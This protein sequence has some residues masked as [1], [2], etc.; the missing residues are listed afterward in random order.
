M[1]ATV[2]N[3]GRFATCAWDGSIIIY[4]NKTRKPDLVIQEHNI[5]VNYILQLS[6]GMLVSCSWDKSIKIFNIKHNNYQ[7]LQTLNYH[8]NFVYKVIELNN[9]NLISCS[10]DSSVIIYSKDNNNKYTKDYKITTNS[11]CFCVIQTKENEIC[12]DELH[13]LNNHSICFWN[14]LG[15]NVI[16]KINN[17][18]WI[19]RN[20]FNMISEDLLLIT[21]IDKLYIV[22][23]NL[24]N[25]IRIINVPGSSY[26]VVSCILN[27][28]IFLTA[29][30]NKNIK[31]WR[32]EG[33]NLKLISTKDNAHDKPIFSLIKLKEGH[34]LS[35]SSNGE[36]KIW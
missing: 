10:H 2:L 23:V 7:L 14:L 8:N 1:C 21:G 28:M 27:K 26:I 30:D 12:Y 13:S 33:N 36:I 5:C 17:L 18:G 35:G 22:N 31:Q 11:D 9:K 3:D 6:T 4:N 29:D 20:S 16:K 34:I 24:Y 32:I 19:G 25:L 15:Q